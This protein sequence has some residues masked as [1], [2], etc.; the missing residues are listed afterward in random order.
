MEV[1]EPVDWENRQIHIRIG[2]PTQVAQTETSIVDI[3]IERWHKN[4]A[5][6][7]IGGERELP[8]GGG[9]NTSYGD[10]GLDI[11]I[12]LRPDDNDD[13]V[14]AIEQLR[15]GKWS[16]VAMV[17]VE[18]TNGTEWKG[19]LV[20]INAMQTEDRLPVFVGERVVMEHMDLRVGGLEPNKVWLLLR[21]NQSAE[22][23]VYVVDKDGFLKRP[24]YELKSGFVTSI[25]RNH[26]HPFPLT[27]WK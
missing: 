17:L 20:F 26:L 19:E 3:G 8:I 2:F 1:I 27:W 7:G 18:D 13:M 9:F 23:G 24:D 21:Q 11:E 5:V 4:S 6:F 14:N 12:R 25:P 15:L 22:N 16:L 10:D